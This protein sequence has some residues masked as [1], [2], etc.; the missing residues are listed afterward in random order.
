MVVQ[1]NIKSS[2]VSW[3]P[4]TYPKNG[5][6]VISNLYYPES[7]AE[8]IELCQRL[9]KEKKEFRIIGLTSNIYIS[10]SFSFGNIISVRKLDTVTVH[11]DCIECDCGV[12]VSK[13]AKAMVG[14][15]IEGFDGLLDLPGTVGGS[16]FGNSS[17]YGFSINS[18]LIDFDLLLPSGEVKRMESSSLNNAYHVT[19][20]KRGKLNGVILSAR[21]KK[22]HGDR[23]LI[24]KN[25]ERIHQ[26][27]KEQQPPPAYNLGS[28]YLERGRR[29]MFFHCVSILAR[30][31]AIFTRK[32]KLAKSDKTR[33]CFFKLIGAKELLPY[34]GNEWNRY[35]W[36]DEKAHDAFPKFLRLH[37]LLYTRSELEIEIW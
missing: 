18:L 14:E 34:V 25:A 20:F 22:R 27:R 37:K 15:G 4:S 2:L 6:G 1:E 35:F 21:L 29:T 31:C 28:M 10:P 30:I 12:I 3:F 19:D 7:K 11:D 17:C 32:T 8:F 13:L 24:E 9:Y 33:Y 26:L 16:V 23:T 36:R 5:G